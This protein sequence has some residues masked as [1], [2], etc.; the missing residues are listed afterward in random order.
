[1]TTISQMADLIG[2]HICK[3]SGLESELKKICFGV[4]VIMVMAISI[5]I[6]IVFGAVLGM[7]AET[8]IMIASVFL[9]KFLI[10]GPHLSGFFRCLIYSVTLILVGAWLCH[11]YPV[12][13]NQDIAWL[14]G[15]FVLTILI[16]MRLL[17]SY[18][19][20]ERKQVITRKM[21]V[22]LMMF[23]YTILFIYGPNLFYA[24]ALIG[25]SISILNTS[26][27]G[28]NFTKWLEQIT[29]QGGAVQ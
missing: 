11:I 18:R 23:C 27:V 2:K 16:G 14:L 28:V 13:L 5:I 25:I 1:M 22:G 8:L 24:G 10:G 6:T 20:L 15:L 26:T 17:P 9:V 21:V 4:E 3:Q 12:W 7:F 19:T 29:K